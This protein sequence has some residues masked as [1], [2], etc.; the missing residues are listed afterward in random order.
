MILIDIRYKDMI[1]KGLISKWIRSVCRFYSDGSIINVIKNFFE[2]MKN[3]KP[4]ILNKKINAL[5]NYEKDYDD[6][7]DKSI[8]NEQ[9]LN[10]KKSVLGNGF[11]S[12]KK[13]I[14]NSTG[15]K[16][17][18]D[19]RNF[20][21]KNDIHFSKGRVVIGN[22]ENIPNKNNEKK[23]IVNKINLKNSLVVCKNIK[24]K[25][26]I[27]NN[28]LFS[29]ED[30]NQFF[31]DNESLF[32]DESSKKKDNKNR[33]NKSININKSKILNDSE[34]E[35]MTQDTP[36]T[37]NKKKEEIP[38]DKIF[39]K[40]LKMKQ[41]SQLE[42]FLGKYN[43]KLDFDEH[44]E[45]NNLNENNEEGKLKCPICFEIQKDNN[46]IHFSVSRC[47]HIICNNC[48]E[49]CL[50]NK[51]ECPICKKKVTKKTLVQLFLN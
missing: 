30:L 34:F 29:Q 16:I 25:E 32:N 3:Y 13:L 10:G 43:L 44:V 24:E 26:N 2:G 39:K 20:E 17:P 11:I 48:W 8:I 27:E 1:Y 38:T 4:K 21:I 22:K 6:N 19:D 33:E 31:N 5:I 12:A 28:I 51:L 23:E 14:D 18:N 47:G 36:K 45:N 41:N 15:K 7:V 40:L 46:E 9:D 42:E 50:N 49:Q 35:I 37:M